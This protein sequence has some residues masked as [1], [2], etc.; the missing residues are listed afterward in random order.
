MIIGFVPNNNEIRY[1]T[2]FLDNILLTFIL[3]YIPPPADDRVI[4]RF[5]T[6][7]FVSK[8]VQ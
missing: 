5:V 1:C 6:I 3:Q 4:V 7:R 8:I 2:F